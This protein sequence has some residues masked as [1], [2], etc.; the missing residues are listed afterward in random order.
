[1]NLV[2]SKLSYTFKVIKW[3]G[4]YCIVKDMFKS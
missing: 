2:L 3:T 1:M 4:K